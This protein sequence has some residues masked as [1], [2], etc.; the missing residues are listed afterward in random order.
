[1]QCTLPFTATALWGSGL[2]GVWGDH[3]LRVGIYFVNEH[4]D[5]AKLILHLRHDSNIVRY[6]ST[7][8]EGVY[9]CRNTECTLYISSSSILSITGAKLPSNQKFLLNLWSWFGQHS[10]DTYWEKRVQCQ[11]ARVT[12]ENSS[13]KDKCNVIF[14]PVAPLAYQSVPQIN[15]FLSTFPLSLGTTGPAD[16]IWAQLGRAVHSSSLILPQK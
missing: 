16:A 7:Q 3:S 13:C 10:K 11:R 1:M 15:H 14:M 4:K 6:Y 12:W 2:Q 9:V 8:Q 5:R